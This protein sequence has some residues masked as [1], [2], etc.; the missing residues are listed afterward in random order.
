[1]IINLHFF[2]FFQISSSNESFST[3]D[4]LDESYEE[5]INKNIKAREKLQHKPAPLLRYKLFFGVQDKNE[6]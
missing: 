6:K 2:F 1:M 4:S 3:D 5:P